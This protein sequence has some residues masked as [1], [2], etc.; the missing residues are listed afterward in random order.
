MI[1]W[2]LRVA[3]LLVC[4]GDCG[5]TPFDGGIPSRPHIKVCHKRAR[6]LYKKSRLIIKKKK[7]RQNSE[8]KIKNVEIKCYFA[9]AYQKPQK[10]QVIMVRRWLSQIELFLLRKLGCYAVVEIIKHRNHC[11]RNESSNDIK[12]WNIEHLL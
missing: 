4:I 10:K 2:C 5:M 9:F 8:H 3:K 12:D 7:R 11:C 1:T 6:E